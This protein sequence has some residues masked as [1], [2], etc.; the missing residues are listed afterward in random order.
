MEK[1]TEQEPEEEEIYL[2][3]IDYS[4]YITAAAQVLTCMQDYEPLTK[5]NQNK[6][7]SIIRKCIRMIDFSINELYNELFTENP[8]ED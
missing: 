2:E 6:K 7:K 3:P 1:S 8:E 5:D 4:I